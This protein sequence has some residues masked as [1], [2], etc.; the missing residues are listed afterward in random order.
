M[1]E[2]TYDALILAGGRARRL[3]GASKPD[4][5]VAGLRLLDLT[6][7]ATATA[8]RRV[9]VGPPSLGLPAGVLHT[10]ESP[11]YGG[12]VAGIEAGLALLPATGDSEGPDDIPV[13]VLACDMPFLSA[14]ASRLLARLGTSDG[15]HLL[16]RNGHAQWLAA[17]YRP[18]ALRRALDALRHDGGTTNASV[19]RLTASLDLT[20]VSVSG[21]ECTDIDTWADWAHVEQVAPALLDASS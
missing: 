19:R 12:P 17:V 18:S 7:I 3:D 11:A 10:Q 13:L 1:A 14:I 2:V 21:E 5:V 9:V 16:D 6:F 20:A 4:L 15:A 8:R